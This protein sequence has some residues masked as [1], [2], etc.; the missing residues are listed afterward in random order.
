VQVSSIQALVSPWMT[1]GNLPKVL[2]AVRVSLVRPPRHRLPQ[3]Q[4]SC[5]CRN[6]I[7]KITPLLV[8]VPTLHQI[9]QKRNTNLTPLEDIG[10]FSSKSDGTHH[11]AG[12]QTTSHRQGQYC[13]MNGMYFGNSN[14]I[15]NDEK[16][17]TSKEGKETENTPIKTPQYLSP[18]LSPRTSFLPVPC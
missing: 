15:I 13:Y 9:V 16:Q 12:Y 8:S 4:F 3:R 14:K 7:T 6:R 1:T 2:N 5:C 17:E 11:H 18:Y 10:T